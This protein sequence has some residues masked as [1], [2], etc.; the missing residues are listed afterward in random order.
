MPPRLGSGREEGKTIVQG[1]PAGRSGLGIFL[2]KRPRPDA[3][4]QLEGLPPRKHPGFVPGDDI[5][6]VPVKGE[7]RRA[8]LVGN[9]PTVK[10]LGSAELPSEKTAGASLRTKILAPDPVVREI[11]VEADLPALD[12]GHHAPLIQRAGE[13]DFTPQPPIQARSFE[14]AHSSPLS[15]TDE[16]NSTLIAGRAQVSARGRRG[17]AGS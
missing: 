4:L 2:K 12:A 13:A 16:D 7:E 6:P 17:G 10:G 9:G 3:V 1:R 11:G 14:P 8:F 15:G 5:P